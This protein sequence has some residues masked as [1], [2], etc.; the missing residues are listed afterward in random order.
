MLLNCFVFINSA[1]LNQGGLRRLLQ[2]PTTCPKIAK[3]ESEQ[4]VKYSLCPSKITSNVDKSRVPPRIEEIECMENSETCNSCYEKH[5]CVQLR[6]TIDVY[7]L[8]SGKDNEII[9]KTEPLTYNSG[10]VCASL[11][12]NEA[13][14]SK[15]MTVQ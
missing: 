5:Q 14:E 9:Y 1:V 13:R 3:R 7:Y 15:V 6:S 8:D 11:P 10:C 2:S 4:V 12:V